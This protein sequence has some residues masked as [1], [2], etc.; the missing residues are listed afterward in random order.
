[1]WGSQKWDDCPTTYPLAYEVCARRCHGL[2][3]MVRVMLQWS[4][5]PFDCFWDFSELYGLPRIIEHTWLVVTGT[6]EFRMTFQKQLGISSSLTIRTSFFRG[7]GSPHQPDIHP[8]GWLAVFCWDGPMRFCHPWYHQ[9]CLQY[10]AY[11][12]WSKRIANS[13]W[14]WMVIN[15]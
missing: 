6:M 9:P 10:S 7:V 1:M 5:Y 4:W 3:S 11:M 12:P 14:P 8:L 15:P 13:P 2:W